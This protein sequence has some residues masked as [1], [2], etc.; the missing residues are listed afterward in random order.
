MQS[1]LLLLQALSFLPT[2]TTAHYNF[3]ALISNGAVQ[4]DWQH[5][6]RRGDIYSNGFHDD[7]NNVTIRC[8]L[9][10]S[11]APSVLSVAAGSSL[12]FRIDE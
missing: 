2:L 12:G 7:V 8:G 11:I 6:R 4:A 10:P 5:V 3:P 1:S 9:T